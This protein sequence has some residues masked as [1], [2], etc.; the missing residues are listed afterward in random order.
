MIRPVIV[1]VSLT[2]S[3][4]AAIVIGIPTAY[5]VERRVISDNN[6]FQIIFLITK[7]AFHIQFLFAIKKKEN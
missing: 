5:R 2:V 7:L 3:R 1:Y 4:N 6:A